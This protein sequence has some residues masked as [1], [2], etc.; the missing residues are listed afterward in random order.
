MPRPNL[1][2]EIWWL[3]FRQATDTPLTLHTE[4]S[5]EV[6]E[7]LWEYWPQDTH[8]AAVVTK[9]TIVQVCSEWRAVGIEFLWEVIPFPVSMNRHRFRRLIDVFKSSASQS[10][11]GYGRWTKRID[12]SLSY[13]E[14]DAE[15]EFHIFQLLEQLH[16][17]QIFTIRGGTPLR[18]PA[19][20]RLL[21]IFETRFNH[22]LLRLDLFLNCYGVVPRLQLSTLSVFFE[23]KVVDQPMPPQF[24]HVSTLTLFLPDEGSV[25]P[26]QWHFPHLHTLAIHSHL[27]ASPNMVPFITLHH[28]T[29][30]HLYVKAYMRYLARKNLLP[31]ICAARYLKSFVTD[32][33]SLN[34]LI[35]LS[36]DES[37]VEQHTWL[38]H[39]GII[40]ETDSTLC[41]IAR[42]VLCH[43]VGAGNPLSSVRVVRI[44][45]TIFPTH[46]T[47]DDQL[48]WSETS[49]ICMDKKVRMEDAE[50]RLISCRGKYL[51]LCLDL[52]S[53]DI[54]SCR[55]NA[56]F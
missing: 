54:V 3:I 11:P 1:P 36:R 41:T 50:S 25:V 32:P 42:D 56:H 8:D 4:W 29:L 51:P 9:R 37:R 23:D 48:V 16:N 21:Q 38:T 20:A 28:R 55:A 34:A 19:H 53:T 24:T 46:I 6:E 47:S 39:L 13:F 52:P 43:L 33:Y 12:C 30:R 14:P 35:Q 10:D 49:R 45:K 26:A 40:R 31:L 5:C 7:R 18:G 15:P 27:A 44:L 17:L 2:L 22:S